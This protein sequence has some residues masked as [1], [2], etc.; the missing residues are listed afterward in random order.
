M[1]AALIRGWHDACPQHYFCNAG[2]SY[3]KAALSQHLQKNGEF[4]P[5][6]CALLTVRLTVT[7][8][9]EP[10]SCCVHYGLTETGQTSMLRC[11][12]RGSIAAKIRWGS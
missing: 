1:H 8:L 4:D 9:A 10:E 5:V 3:E 2:L 7:V 11:R 6:S 12:S